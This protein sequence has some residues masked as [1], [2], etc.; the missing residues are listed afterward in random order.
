MAHWTQVSDRCPLGYLFLSYILVGINY[1]CQ[2]DHI[3]HTPYIG[4]LSLMGDI[5]D[6][7]PSEIS[8]SKNMAKIKIPLAQKSGTCEMNRCTFSAAVNYRTRQKRDSVF[9]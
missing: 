8:V 3:N 1:T 6:F 9:F 5:D 7:L 2:T 4:L